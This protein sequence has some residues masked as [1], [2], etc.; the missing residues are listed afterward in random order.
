MN[1]KRGKEKAS[2]ITVYISSLADKPHFTFY[3]Y[4]IVRREY[5]DGS[6]VR[7]LNTRSHVMYVE[8]SLSTVVYHNTA[9]DGRLFG[10][11]IVPLVISIAGISVLTLLLLL[12]LPLRSS[13]T[14]S[15]RDSCDCR[16]Q[17]EWQL[18]LMNKTSIPCW[19]FRRKKS[20]SFI[21]V[22]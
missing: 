21:T 7:N 18:E 20:E 16:H 8:G 13:D 10:A 2:H 5:Q 6:T 9:M 22:I 1:Y 15:F 12:H 14:R 19:L 11:S 4:I 3:G 17:C